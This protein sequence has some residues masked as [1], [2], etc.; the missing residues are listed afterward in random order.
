MKTVVLHGAGG[1]RLAADVFGDGADSPVVLLHGGGQTRFA[2]GTTPQVLADRGWLVYRVDLR[3]HGESAWP[4][5]GDYSLWAFAD[6][7]RMIAAAMPSLPVLV[8][9]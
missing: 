4:E 8:G 2:W 5:D 6:D 7:T 9:A 3:G 1:V